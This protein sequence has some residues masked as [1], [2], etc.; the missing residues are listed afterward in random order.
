MQ[1]VDDKIRSGLSKVKDL[2]V[3]YSKNLNPTVDTHRVERT[4]ITC[5]FDWEVF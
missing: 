2:I 3:A 4:R 1:D 5:P